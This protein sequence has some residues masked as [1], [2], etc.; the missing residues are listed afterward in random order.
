MKITQDCYDRY[1]QPYID[2]DITLENDLDIIS[3]DLLKKVVILLSDIHD[4]IGRNTI[5]E[6]DLAKYKEIFYEA[7]SKLIE[8][9]RILL[10]FSHNNIQGIEEESDK[11]AKLLMV[12][13]TSYYDENANIFTRITQISK[14]TNRNTLHS[15]V[16]TAIAG[17][18]FNID[19]NII[20]ENILTMFLSVSRLLSKIEEDVTSNLD[21]SLLEILIYSASLNILFNVEQTELTWQ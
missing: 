17:E 8:L 2:E 3:T 21:S 4:T 10:A 18:R 9:N 11:L 14:F 16:I 5:E 20:R 1:I 7:K 6:N 12:S 15:M 19:I 13:G